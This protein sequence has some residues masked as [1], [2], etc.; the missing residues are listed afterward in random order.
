MDTSAI[1]AVD[2][3]TSSTRAALYKAD[4]SFSCLS[5]VQYGVLRP[6]AFMEE[7]DPDLVR[8]SAYQA[9]AACLSSAEAAS[10]RVRGLSFS[11][12]M[13]SVFPV[14]A[15]DRPLR[16]SIPWSDGR[17]E[18]IA[19][20]LRA[21]GMS[22]TLYHATG[23]PVSSIY[24]LC[25]ILWL[26]K[27]E[28][29]VCEKAAKFVSVKDYVLHSLT[30]EWVA[31]HSMASGT[32]M[33]SV[34]RGVWAE[35]A[36]RCA[37][38]SEG[39]L[40][41]LLP[42]DAPLPFANEALRKEWGLPEDIVIFLGGGD[43]PLANLGS[44]AFQPGAAN[45]DLGT[46]GAVRA[47]MD[48]P[49]LD[50]QGRLWCYSMVSGLW[51]YG[52]ILSN[53]GNALQWLGQNVA[54]FRGDISAGDSA[55]RLGAL[56]GEV[57]PGAGGMFFL[58][59]LRKARS[60]YWDDRLKGAMHNLN[61]GH[62]IRHM[63]RAMLEA[64]AYDLAA[65]LDIVAEAVPLRSPV[66]FTGGLSRIQT[67]PQLMADVM[68]REIVTLDT[69]EGSLAGAAIVGLHGAGL[70]SGL[71]FERDYAASRTAFA[72]DKANH[73]LYR[74][75]RREYAEL[76]DFSRN[77]LPGTTRTGRSGNAAPSWKNI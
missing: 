31:D 44:G 17:A 35:E 8:H 59:Y 23:C 63:A 50:E 40:P 21:R 5:Q 38:V 72:P 74:T 14:D 11:S 68:G 15:E 53:V 45:M 52:G 7:Q 33:F 77:E 41:R 37:G 69:C 67:L 71:A 32:G 56:A 55:A 58:P 3:G 10:F 13:Y 12:Q 34:T 46:S 66:I 43:G 25:K 39:Q 6:A 70:L 42:G 76:V 73:E 1:L 24:P 47:A 54:D 27:H 49:A 51:T 57:S 60:P 20:E 64:M 36:L 18:D 75:L 28:P 19:E 2:I 30:G 65:I 62:D 22:E 29:V 61:A 9:I 48:R 16:N 4:G 26:R